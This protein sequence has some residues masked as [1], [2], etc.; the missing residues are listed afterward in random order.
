[1]KLKPALAAFAAVATMAWLPWSAQAQA[2]NC[3]RNCLGAMA[4][5][6]LASIVAHKPASLPLSTEYAA[7]E[8]NQPAALPMMT[9]WNTMTAVK[10]KYYVVDPVSEQ[11]FLIATLAEGSHNVLLF[12]RLKVQNRQLT[13]IE[14]FT[15]RSRANGG[16]Q[17]DADGVAHFP[18]AW[19]VPLKPQQRAPRKVLLQAGL[20]IFDTGVDSPPVAEDCLLM[21]NGKVV[22]ED[23]EVLKYVGAPDGKPETRRNPDG[24]VPIACGVPPFRPT[25]PLARTDIMDEESGVVVSL[26]MVSGNVEPYV[27]TKPTD[28]A[29]VPF[30]MLQPYE[31][32]LKVQ[33]ASGLYHGPTLRVMPATLAV[34]QLHRVFDGKVQ[35]MMMLQNMAPIGAKSPWALA[36]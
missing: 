30:A 13:E 16:F 8:N 33:R 2:A 3:N 5:Q 34:A 27:I 4:D 31:D 36:K 23:P 7:T 22:G 20:S 18:A 6:V 21:E 19:T 14:L 25:D 11:L 17:F 35:G 26:A 9:L 29:F 1:M 28:S 24:T 32:M 15:D 12:G 10:A